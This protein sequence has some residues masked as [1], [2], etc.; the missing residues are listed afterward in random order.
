M[1][2]LVI[3]D[4]AD[5]RES[6][7]LLLGLWGHQVLLAETGDDGLAMA[8]K[9]APDVALIDIG[10]PGMSGY[11]I[12]ARIRAGA[13]G[14]PGAMR[15][16]AMTGYGQPDDRRRSREAGIHHHF[17]KPVEPFVLRTLLSNLG[18]P[19]ASGRAF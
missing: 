19:V 2:I 8:L 16:V 3:E 9:E 5:I 6:L 1:R 15:L 14:R 11:E 17:V 13:A 12:A 10:L 18:A 4:N 7:S